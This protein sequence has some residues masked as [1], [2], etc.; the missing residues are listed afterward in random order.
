MA[1]SPLKE[2]LR[3]IGPLK[4]YLKNPLFRALENLKMSFQKCKFE[5]PVG[6]LK[7]DF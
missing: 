4:N 5:G 1:W 6:P 7:N 3:I 2:C